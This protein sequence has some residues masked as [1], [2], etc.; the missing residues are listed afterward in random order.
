M[1]QSM[2]GTVCRLSSSALLALSFS[3]CFCTPCAR[4]L[5]LKLSLAASRHP[6]PHALRH[7]A[8]LSVPLSLILV[9]VPLTLVPSVVAFPHAISTR[10]PS[11]GNTHPRRILC[12][13]SYAVNDKTR[14]QASAMLFGKEIWRTEQRKH[15]KTTKNLNSNFEHLAQSTF[16]IEIRISLALV[17]KVFFPNIYTIHDTTTS[18]RAWLE[19]RHSCLREM[20]C[21]SPSKSW[22][23][24]APD[25]TNRQSFSSW[26][27]L[28]YSQ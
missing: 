16:K 22:K 17:D 12:S 10:Q 15:K 23:K 21:T 7:H 8:Y 24:T 1:G 18:A 14:T 20:W 6:S 25:P 9:S 26:H 3:C 11:H 13:R 2:P 19:P 27:M 5:S 4:I 28:T